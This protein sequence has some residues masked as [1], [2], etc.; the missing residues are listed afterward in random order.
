MIRCMVFKSNSESLA[1][2]PWASVEGFGQNG[3]QILHHQGCGLMNVKGP[4]VILG[5]STAWLFMILWATRWF[6]R[7]MMALGWY[8]ILIWLPSVE[9]SKFSFFFEWWHALPDS[10]VGRFCGA[11][12]E[13]ELYWGQEGIAKAGVNAIGPGCS[14]SGPTL[15]PS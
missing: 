8:C 2:W 14:R 13:A 7:H 9:R 1:V 10:S 5:A 6:T 3:L 4:A 12:G 11:C 15:T